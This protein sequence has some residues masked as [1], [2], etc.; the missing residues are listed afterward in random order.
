M[1]DKCTNILKEYV[2]DNLNIDSVSLFGNFFSEIG[3]EILGVGYSIWHKRNENPIHSK[4]KSPN[5]FMIEQY[6]LKIIIAKVET[7]QY[8]K[9][10]WNEE[11]NSR[12]FVQFTIDNL[13]NNF[14]SYKSLIFNSIKFNEKTFNL[15]CST[16]QNIDLEECV[17]E[18]CFY[19]NEKLGKSKMTQLLKSIKMEGNNLLKKLSLSNHFISNDQLFELLKDLSSC[20]FFSELYLSKLK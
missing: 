1:S 15:L 6:L 18:N 13:S 20:S 16:I 19:E 7:V 12:R 9:D 4:E 14:S 8:L 3:A 2:E 10:D 11:L 5:L 17:V